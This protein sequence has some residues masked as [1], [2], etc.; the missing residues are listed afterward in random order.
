M[1][2]GDQNPTKQTNKWERSSEETETVWV[3]GAKDDLRITLTRIQ[4]I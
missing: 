4:K 3:E 2:N 1:R